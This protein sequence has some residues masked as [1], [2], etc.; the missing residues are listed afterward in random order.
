MLVTRIALLF[1]LCLTVFG[2]AWAEDSDYKEMKWEELMPSGAAAKALA[3]SKMPIHTSPNFMSEDLAPNEYQKEMKKQQQSAVVRGDLKDKLIKIAGFTVPLQTNEDGALTEFF[4]VPF[5]G[6][7]IHVPPPPTNQIIHVT[8]EKGFKLQL[9]SQPV[10]IYGKIQTDAVQT[11]IADSGYEMKAE[12][13][14][15]YSGWY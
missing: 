9:M 3:E 5:V 2:Q 8:Y 13:V 12:K 7:C 4:L 1:S 11:D 10:W 14:E 15:A 6:A